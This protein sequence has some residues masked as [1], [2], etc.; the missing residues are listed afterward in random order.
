MRKEWSYCLAKKQN[1]KGDWRRDRTE[2]YLLH[3]CGHQEENV[4]YFSKNDFKMCLYQCCS[5]RVMTGISDLQIWCTAFEKTDSL[6]SI[7]GIDDWVHG[8]CFG[9]VCRRKRGMVPWEPVAKKKKKKSD[10]GQNLVKVRYGTCLWKFTTG[11]HCCFIE[12]H[13]K[14]TPALLKNSAFP[15][16]SSS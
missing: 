3:S 8:G 13:T 5:F 10:V 2:L 15:S 4:L 1:G 7:T 12:C 6:I 16:L 9:S 11:C 14:I